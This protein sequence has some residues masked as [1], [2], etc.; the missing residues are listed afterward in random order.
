MARK[1]PRGAISAKGRKYAID[2]GYSKTGTSNKVRGLTD[3][4][5]DSLLEVED[6]TDEVV[7]KTR[8]ALVRA[9]EAIGIQAEGDAMALCPVDTG[10]LRNSI[11]HSI[12][13]GDMTA[14]VGTNVEYAEFVHNGTSTHAAQPF[15]TDAVEANADTYRKIA[16]AMLRGA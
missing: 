7:A 6:H 9:L 8:D 12:D 1:R 15:L 10:R 3:A 11:T 4:D 13:D 14:V 5:V 16:E 2:K